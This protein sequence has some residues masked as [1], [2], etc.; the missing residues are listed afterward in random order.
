MAE[1]K[2]FPAVKVFLESKQDLEI[3]GYRPRMNSRHNRS[4]T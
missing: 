4:Q 3:I 2:S 1:V